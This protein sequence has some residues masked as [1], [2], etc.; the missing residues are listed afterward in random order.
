MKYTLPKLPYSYESLKG[1]SKQVNEWHHDKHYASYVNGRN[2][3]EEKLAKMRASSDWAGV[4]SVM[5]AQSH[6]VSGS[7][8][9]NIYY[10]IMGGDGKVDENLEVVKS[11]NKY[12]G[13][14]ETWKNEF[15]EIAKISRGWAVLSHD[16]SDGELHNA[17][18]DFHDEEVPWGF[19]PILACDVWEHAYYY[20][21]GPDRGAY[22]D[23]F[24]QNLNWSNVNDLYLQYQALT[25]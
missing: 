6:N 3:V 1:I 13:S 16:V 8:L 25:V 7:I 5:L 18:T 24:F 2:E 15:T 19:L 23:A 10:S 22:L 12:F 11:I 4:R 9:H 20:D 14:Y 17:M 21:Y